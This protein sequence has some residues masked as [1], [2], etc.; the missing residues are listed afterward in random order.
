MDAVVDQS[1]AA[2]LRADQELV[3]GPVRVFAAERARGN[4]EY[5]EIALWLERKSPAEFADG[6]VATRILH[7]REMIEIDA[8][9]PGRLDADVLRSGCR[10]KLYR[11]Q[12]RHLHSAR[13]PSR[14]SICDQRR[15][16]KAATETIA[17][18]PA[19]DGLDHLPD[20]VLVKLR[21]AGNGDDF[22]GETFGLRQAAC[23]ERP[24]IAG[25]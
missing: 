13:Q 1:G 18:L 7:P 14:R 8:A 4:A 23:G 21:K 2:T 10:L 3:A 24:A 22:Q 6:E 11:R 9:H 17:G 25:L 19:V 12:I 15:Y 20:F 5:N 16:H